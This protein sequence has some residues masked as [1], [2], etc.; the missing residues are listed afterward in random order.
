[1]RLDLHPQAARARL[2]ACVGSALTEGGSLLLCA[3][4]QRCPVETGRLRGSGYARVDGETCEVG[5]C[6][7]YA[8]CVHERQNK[9]LEGPVNDSGV[10]AQI[11]SVFARL[12]EL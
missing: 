8:A 12:I 9:F 10:Q 5:F 3:A 1:M 6:A 7:P 11:L 2:R 4:Q